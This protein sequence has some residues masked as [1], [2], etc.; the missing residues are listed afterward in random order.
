MTGGLFEGDDEVAGGVDGL[1]L[2]MTTHLGDKVIGFQFEVVPVEAVNQSV[3]AHCFHLFQDLDLFE[4]FGCLKTL[5]TVVKNQRVLFFRFLHKIDGVIV[6]DGEVF[7]LPDP[8]V[9]FGNFDHDGINFDGGNGGL[10]ITA[11][12]ILDD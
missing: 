6:D 1:D 5:K 10:W 8:E 4:T 9:F 11:M 2:E 7:D 3:V 12:Q